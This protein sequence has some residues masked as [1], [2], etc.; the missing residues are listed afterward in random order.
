M[1]AR[2][3]KLADLVF[4]ATCAALCAGLLLRSGWHARPSPASIEVGDPMP[5]VAGIGY[6]RSAWTIMLSVHSQCPGCS[7]SVGF[8]RRVAAERARVASRV[9]IVAASN[10][11]P[12]DLEG[13]L[14]REGV[15]VDR[16]LRI[17][18]G[19]LFDAPVPTIF[20]IDGTGRVRGQWAGAVKG[21]RKQ[22]LLTQMFSRVKAP[23]GWDS[24]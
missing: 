18:S 16:V 10:E 13:F 17:T 23:G 7:E 4:A 11:E 20:L 12:R 9:R 1:T 2:V 15:A 5:A 3:E 24:R 21:A 14:S 22:Q 19:P 6:D 8:Y